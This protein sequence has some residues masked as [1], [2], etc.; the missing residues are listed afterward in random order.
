MTESVLS[1]PLR[2]NDGRAMPWIGLGTY[3][4]PDGRSE[5]LTRL[6]LELGYPAVDTA[7]FYGNEAEVGRG[8]RAHGGAAPFVT[9]K[10]W[11]DALGFD[12]A[13]RAFDRSEHALGLGAFDLYLIHWPEPERGLYVETWRALIRLR[14]EGR[15]GS[16]GVSNFTEA[17]LARIIDATG[18]VPAVNQVECHPR[19]QQQALRAHCRALGVA[20][21]AWSPL[22]RAQALAEPAIAAVARKHG[23]SAA[24][25]V[26]RWHLQDGSII[27]PKASSRERLAENLA[28]FDFA[29]DEA[30]MAAIAALDSPDGR[31]GPDPD[32]PF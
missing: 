11:R 25:V 29:L 10:L 18:V 15:V 9:T 22:G 30:D 8:V 17:H 4:M 16:I 26:L 1:S 6:A 7:S 23:R 21:T 13:L 28:V 32:T 27:I 20:F 31:L 2:L 5:A 12:A 3:D 14:D 19:F 24:Q